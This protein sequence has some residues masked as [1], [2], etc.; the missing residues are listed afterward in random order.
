MKH[1]EKFLDN[2]LN[3]LLI[4]FYKQVAQNLFTKFG[5]K[6]VEPSLKH[7][8]RNTRSILFTML[9]HY[10]VVNEGRSQGF[11]YERICDKKYEKDLVL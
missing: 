1:T 9:H 6:Y 8:F 7:K 5:E 11:E 2:S 10:Y 4:F 3:M